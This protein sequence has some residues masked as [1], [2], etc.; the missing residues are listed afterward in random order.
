MPDHRL[1]AC[2]LNFITGRTAET[3]AKCSAFERS[4]YHREPNCGS[5]GASFRQGQRQCTVKN[6]ARCKRVNHVDNRGWTV[7]QGTFLEPKISLLAAAGPYM[8]GIQ[9]SCLP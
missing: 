4:R 5:H 3:T 1:S 9:R 8:T 2:S 7:A 6:I